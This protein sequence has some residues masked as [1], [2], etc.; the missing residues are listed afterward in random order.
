MPTKAE[1]E[2]ELEALKASQESG[3]DF[4]RLR[5]ALKA[6]AKLGGRQ[7]AIATDALR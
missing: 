6:I 1:L 4:A 2:A 3:A 7:G 5:D